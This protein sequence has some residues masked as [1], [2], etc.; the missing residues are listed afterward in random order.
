MTARVLFGISHHSSKQSGK[1]HFSGAQTTALGKKKSQCKNPFSWNWCDN[2]V[3][4]PLFFQTASFVISLLI[5][6]ETSA[7]GLWS[8]NFC[9]A[10]IRQLFHQTSR[11]TAAATTM[12]TRPVSR[13][14]Q[15][16]EE[17]EEGH[18]QGD[19]VIV[20]VGTGEEDMVV[21]IGS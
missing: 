3:K 16:I 4:N 14:S 18:R 5:D 7:S 1:I 20:E 21:E 13:V 2:Q 11:A 12:L 8:T 9:S 19:G 6:T 15:S 17:G 10:S